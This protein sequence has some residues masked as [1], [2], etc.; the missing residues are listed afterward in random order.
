[1]NFDKRL[2]KST[3]LFV[4]WKLWTEDLKLKTGFDI[5]LAVQGVMFWKIA[6][7]LVQNSIFNGI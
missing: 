1:M 5:F 4:D 3:G 7:K 6:Q 2:L